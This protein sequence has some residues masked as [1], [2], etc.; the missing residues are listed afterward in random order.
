MSMIPLVITVN[1]VLMD[2][3]VMHKMVLQTIVNHVHVQED[4]HVIKSMLLVQ[5]DPLVLTM[6]ILLFAQIVPKEAPVLDVILV[7]K[8]ILV[9]LLA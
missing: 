5:V 6:V 1:N 2:F 4:L 3:T 8:T 9:I 7:K